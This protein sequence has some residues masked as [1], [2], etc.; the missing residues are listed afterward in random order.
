VST[1]IKRH[2]ESLIDATRMHSTLLSYTTGKHGNLILTT[3]EL[4]MHHDY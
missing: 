2:L 3:L 1:I 4:V